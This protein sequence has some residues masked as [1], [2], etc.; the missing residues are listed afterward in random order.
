M[1]EPRDF[2]WHVVL[3]GRVQGVGFRWHTRLE[4]RAIGVHGWV[5]NRED[6][7]VE[8]R[9]EGHPDRLE[10]LLAWF[11]DGPSGARVD[12]VDVRPVEPEALPG[13]EIR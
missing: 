12:V 4:A 9:V 10:E 2:A 11:E 6:G 1:S 3:D 5:C 7:A 8:A 13:F